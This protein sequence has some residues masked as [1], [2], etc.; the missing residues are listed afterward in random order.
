VLF[1]HAP[2]HSYLFLHVF[3]VAP[4]VVDSLAALGLVGAIFGDRIGHELGVCTS[5]NHITMQ[6]EAPPPGHWQRVLLQLQPTRPQLL[7][8]AAGFHEFARMRKAQQA[9]QLALSA[10]MTCNNSCSL[11]VLAA[12]NIQSASAPAAA[13][14]SEQGGG[15]A[16]GSCDGAAAAS[17]NASDTATAA[18]AVAAPAE[19][20]SSLADRLLR[21]LNQ[22]FL[23]VQVVMLNTLTRKQIA[24]LVVSSFP[25]VPRAAPL[26]EAALEV[27]TNQKDFAPTLHSASPE[28]LRQDEQHVFSAASAAAEGSNS[29]VK[30]KQRPKREVEE[31]A[32]AAAAAQKCTGIGQPHTHMQQ[33]M[34]LLEQQVQQWWHIVQCSQLHKRDAFTA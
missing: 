9:A 2:P 18:A 8:L 1:V 26:M 34:Q 25:Y 16:G 23:M 29:S 3:R 15:D 32:A 12:A 5:T 7:H 14:A 31:Q 20:C 22:S 10:Q 17:C 6:Q 24:Q 28:A 13:D 4:Q 21:M 27:L 11:Q 19:A 33:R 30:G